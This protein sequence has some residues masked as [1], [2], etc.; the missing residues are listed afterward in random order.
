MVFKKLKTFKI[1]KLFLRSQV[2]FK[3]ILNRLKILNL[4]KF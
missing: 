1:I 2:K 4:D 3:T